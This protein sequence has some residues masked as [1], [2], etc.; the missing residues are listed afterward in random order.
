MREARRLSRC[1]LLE[2]YR[3]RFLSLVFKARSFSLLL[4]SKI[5]RVFLQLI[6]NAHE[7]LLSPRA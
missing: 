4:H 6:V 3:L 1:Y 7:R 5:A 2:N